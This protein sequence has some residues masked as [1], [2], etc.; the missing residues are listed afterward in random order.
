MVIRVSFAKKNFIFTSFTSSNIHNMSVIKGHTII[1][2]FTKYFIFSKMPQ[3]LNQ[4]VIFTVGIRIIIS[5]IFIEIPKPK[6][7]LL[8]KGKFPTKYFYLSE[9]FHISICQL[10]SKE[11]S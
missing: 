3:K 6:K 10:P 9:N 4:R 7:K 11:I 5:P 2:D 1:R 8:K